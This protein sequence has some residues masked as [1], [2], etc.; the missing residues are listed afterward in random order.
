MG[1]EQSLKGGVFPDGG[2]P[3]N[4]HIQDLRKVNR[5]EGGFGTKREIHLRPSPWPAGASPT[6]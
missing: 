6:E 1:G 4:D 2:G 5:N 3:E